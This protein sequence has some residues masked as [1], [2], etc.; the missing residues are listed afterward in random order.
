MYD[1]HV[2]AR[3][4][5]TRASTCVYARARP[6]L[7]KMPPGPGPAPPPLPALSPADFNA[8][9]PQLDLIP[10]D[11]LSAICHHPAVALES[12]ALRLGL[13]S[14]SCQ[15]QTYDMKHLN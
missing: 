12:L 6:L 13:E 9:F 3:V 14:A 1:I 8:P 15:F 2:L 5:Y 10:H 11:F 7:A 4:L